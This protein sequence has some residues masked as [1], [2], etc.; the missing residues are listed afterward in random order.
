MGIHMYLFIWR[1]G[2]GSPTIMP[3]LAW[4]WGASRGQRRSNYY[5]QRDEDD[6]EVAFEDCPPAMDAWDVERAVQ[7]AKTNKLGD[8]VAEAL[9]KHAV[10]GAALFRLTEG[11]AREVHSPTLFSPLLF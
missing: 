1:P 9:K 6:A 3:L 10:D 5:G 2:D 11:D 4:S 8:A 7:W